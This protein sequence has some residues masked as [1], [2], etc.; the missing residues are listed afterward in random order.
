MLNNKLYKI[1]A[2]VRL[3]ASNPQG[4]GSI[5]RTFHVQMNEKTKSQGF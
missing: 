5:I 1:M 4:I 2:Y 3:L